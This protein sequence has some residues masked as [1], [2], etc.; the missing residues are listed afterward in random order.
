MRGKVLPGETGQKITP[1][2]T[3][4]S[5]KLE[6]G[7]FFKWSPDKIKCFILAKLGM[8]GISVP[9]LLSMADSVRKSTVHVVG[10][11]TPCSI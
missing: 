3:I 2:W 5:I 8:V 6:E 10:D 4:V 1:F 9:V 7:I 11:L